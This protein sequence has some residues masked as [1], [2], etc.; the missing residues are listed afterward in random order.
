VP[1]LFAYSAYS[2]LASTFGAFATSLSLYLGPVVGALLSVIFLGEA[3]GVVHLIGGALSL[4]GMWLSLR[5]RSGGEGQ[6]RR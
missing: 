4:G 6:A 3:P 1:G 2:Y 5:G